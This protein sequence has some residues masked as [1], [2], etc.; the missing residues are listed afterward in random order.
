MHER[1]LPIE[2]GIKKVKK[3]IVINYHGSTIRVV[4]VPAG[5]RSYLL[6]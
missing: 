4:G 2:W 1:P 3:P 5:P 6:E